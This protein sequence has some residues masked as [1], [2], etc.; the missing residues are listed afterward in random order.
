M[1]SGLQG[2]SILC[3]VFVLFLTPTLVLAAPAM[4][5]AVQEAPPVDLYS[6]DA[7]WATLR[8]MGGL[9]ILVAALTNIGKK[10]LPKYFPDG[11]APKWS[12][13]L[14]VLGFA[15][16]A[17][18]QLSG[19]ADLIPVIDKNAELIGT[20]L[21]TL[22]VIVLQLYGS[23]VAHDNVLAGLPVIGKSFTSETGKYNPVKFLSKDGLPP[24]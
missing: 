9:A 4:R 3:I 11:S 8:S 16:V 18:L 23:R 24:F 10:Y 7:V 15:L 1:R 13:I 5:H 14:N 20:T 22:L 17:S 12:L 2:L 21:T 6:A 19:R